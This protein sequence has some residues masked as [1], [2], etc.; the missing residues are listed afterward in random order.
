[1]KATFNAYREATSS[2]ENGIS[3]YPVMEAAVLLRAS[4]A[5][6]R[7]LWVE[8]TMEKS[9]IQFYFNLKGNVV[10]HFGPHYQIPLGAGKSFLI[11]NPLQDLPVRI[12][13][14][15]NTQLVG[16]MVT[17]SE[18]HQLLMEQPELSFLSGERINQKFYK[19]SEIGPNLRVVLEQIISA[20]P[21][22][23]AKNLYFKGKALELLSFYF[24]REEK[25]SEVAC[26][27]LDD[28]QNV[29][30]IRQA[31]RILLDRM[32]EPPALKD[33]AREV[34]LN[35]YRLKAGF[36][37]IYG[38]SPYHY[39]T[40]HRMDQAR[41]LMQEEGLKVNEV[42]F[43]VGYN[44]PS[45]FIAAFKKRFGITPKKFLSSLQVR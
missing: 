14:E 38:K 27:F 26:P 33:L 18:L 44:N 35:E 17:V 42:A 39:L 23:T 9:L 2:T 1:M 32:T 41:K 28:E 13:L 6:E 45:H 10:F 19:E 3:S 25:K 43:A 5:E 24:Q 4:N 16:L 7:T 12:A 8:E 37:N 29:V 34:G 20:Q 31:R 40:D 11:Y 22:S 21:G 15:Q 30:R 36:K